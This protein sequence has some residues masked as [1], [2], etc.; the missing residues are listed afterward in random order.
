MSVDT[1]IFLTLYKFVSKREGLK[2]ALYFINIGSSLFFVALYTGCVLGLLISLDQ[3]LIKFLLVPALVLM[4]V[5]ILRKVINRKR[6]FEVLEIEPIM[7][8]DA[9]G[10]FPSKHASSAMIIALS[11][12]WINPIAGWVCICLALFTAISRVLAG[13][14]YPLDVLTGIFISLLFSIL[15][16]I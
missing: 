8:H 7:I 13:V 14:H 16:F 1:K 12:Y 11:V 10:S 3:L 9:D 4:T 2:K 6:P 5:T 15:F